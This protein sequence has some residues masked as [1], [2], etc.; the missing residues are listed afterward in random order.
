MDRNVY[1]TTAA[2]LAAAVRDLRPDASSLVS[3]DWCRDTMYRMGITRF[4]DVDRDALHAIADAV[5]QL[6][7]EGGRAFVMLER[8]R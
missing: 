4:E 6:A 7:D 3:T 8:K 1:L 5:D 2:D